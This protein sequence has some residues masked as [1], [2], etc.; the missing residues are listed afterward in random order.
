MNVDL[1][2]ITTEGRN[3]NTTNIDVQSTIDILK[4]INNEDK[5]VPYAVEKSTDSNSTTR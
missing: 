5:T 4:L 2:K 3:S 1:K